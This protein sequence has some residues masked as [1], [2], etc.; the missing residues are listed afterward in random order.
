MDRG[1]R[2]ARLQTGLSHSQILQATLLQGTL[3]PAHRV[4]E[5]GIAQ[6]LQVEAQGSGEGK[7]GA[8]QTGMALSFEILREG[9]SINDKEQIQKFKKNHSIAIL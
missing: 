3:Q 1:G 7:G 6:Q 2:V 5:T 9:L 8:R 4:K